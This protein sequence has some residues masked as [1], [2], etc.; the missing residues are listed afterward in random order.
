MILSESVAA[1]QEFFPFFTGIANYRKPA[2]VKR[3]AFHNDGIL[4]IDN[5]IDYRKFRPFFTQLIIESP[6]SLVFP[7]NA[8]TGNYRKFLES[9]GQVANSALE[10]FPIF[11]TNN[12][13]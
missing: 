10:F 7:K 11:Y 1:K 6:K 5:K 4:W 12:Q 9:N 3:R 13:L 2:A 8:G